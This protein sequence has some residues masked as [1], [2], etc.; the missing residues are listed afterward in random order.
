MCHK[1][2]VLVNDNVCCGQMQPDP[3]ENGHAVLK[4]LFS[5][6]MLND[7]NERKGIKY[8]CIIQDRYS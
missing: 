8:V 5:W 7:Y 1:V 6:G 4:D 2:S 3:P